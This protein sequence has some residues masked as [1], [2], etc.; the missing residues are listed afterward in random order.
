MGVSPL[1][2]FKKKNKN[3]KLDLLGKRFAQKLRLCLLHGN[4]HFI[5][6]FFQSFSYLDNLNNN[7]N[8]IKNYSSLNEISLISEIKQYFD[9]LGKGNGTIH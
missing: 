1:K 7:R 8:G 3:K 9:F 5:P 2:H 4:R 6:C